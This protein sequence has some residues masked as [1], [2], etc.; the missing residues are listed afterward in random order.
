MY[1]KPRA[2]D[3][4]GVRQREARQLGALGHLGHGERE[5]AQPGA[6]A[7]DE[8]GLL[9]DHALRRVLRLLD[10]SP[11]SMTTSL[12]FAPPSALMPPAR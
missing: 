10:V 4:I 3:L 1:L 8:F 7:A 11:A 5:R 12:S 6:G 2:G 9:R